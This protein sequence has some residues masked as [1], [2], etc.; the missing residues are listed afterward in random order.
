MRGQGLDPDERPLVKY[1]GNP[2]H[3]YILQRY[4][5]THD[6]TH[7]LFG[8]GISVSEEIAIKWFEMLQTELPMNAL[9]SFVGP[10]NLVL[11]QRDLQQ[12][13]QLTQVYLPHVLMNAKTS[14]LLMSVYFEKYF[15]TDL[16]DF[17]K[18]LGIIPLK[19][20]KS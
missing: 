13:N 18:Q 20:H 11:F 10:L 17:R 16:D 9:A 14:K 19:E 1:V 15:E 8:Y 6:M 3:A 7:R 2:E 4:K 5:E 12:L